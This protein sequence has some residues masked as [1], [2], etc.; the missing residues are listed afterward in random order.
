MSNTVYVALDLEATDMHPERGEIIELGAI[1]FT[2][3]RIVDRWSATVRPRGPV[4]FAITELTG[5]TRDEVRRAAPF[6]AVAPALT[7]FLR[8][9]PIVGQ[10]VW[11][12]VAMLRAA[13]LTLANPIYD[14]FE[15][16]TLTLPGLPAYSLR[17]I[18]ARLAVELPVEH[19]ALADAAVT[20]EVFRKLVDRLNEFDPETIGEIAALL[21]TAKSPLAPLVRELARE[22]TRAGFDSPV[23]ALGAAMRQQIAGRGLREERSMDALFLLPRQRPERLEPTGS[24]ARI[25]PADLRALFAPEGAFA[26]AFPG[27][28]YRVSQLRMMEAVAKA[29]NDGQLLVAEA[30]TG[31]GKA[32]DV[33]TPI[34]TPTGWKR[35]GD[36]QAGD[37]V[38]DESGQ[39]CTVTTAWPIMHERPC[40]EV[41]FSDGST[42]IADE[43]HLWAS[44]TRSDRARDYA[45]GRMPR[46]RR[47]YG[48]PTSIVKASAAFEGATADATITI[49]ALVALLDGQH[50]TLIRNAV[51][52]VRPVGDDDLGV[53]LY[54]TG[55]L[56]TPVRA[57]LEAFARDQ[58]RH[59]ETPYSV[60]T[61]A[62]ML[63]TLHCPG[64]ARN[65][66][67]RTAGIVAYPEA[68][69]PIAPYYLGIWLGDGNANNSGITTADD[70]VLRGIETRGY[71]TRKL[72][73]RYRYAVYDE[74]GPGKNRW[75]P[76][77]TRSLRL[78]GVLRNKHVPDLYLTASESQRRDLLAGLLDSGGT[79]S[80]TGAIEFTSTD[81]QL[82]E[83][84][85]ELACSLG[86][87]ATIKESRAI[88]NGKDCGAEWMITFTTSDDLF[89]LSRKRQAQCQRLR[90]HNPERN[91]YRY[92]VDI[93]PVPSRPVRC[94]AVDS[95]THLYLAGKTFIP[96]HNSVAYLIPAVIHAVERGETVVIST[97]TIGL[98]DQLFRKDI[99][100]VLRVLGQIHREEERA[101]GADDELEDGAESEANP[102]GHAQIPGEFVAALLKGRSNYLCLRRWFAL[103]K[104]SQHEAEEAHLLAKTMAW[105]QETDSGDRAELLLLPEEGRAW[106]KLAEH[107]GSC[108]SSQC[109]FQKRGQCFLY[110]A[111]R[112][113]ESAQI[114]VVNHALLLSDLGT[115]GGVLPPYQHLIID[116]AHH[117][118]AEATRQFGF[119]LDAASLV[120]HLDQIRPPAGSRGDGAGRAP[121]GSASVGA[122]AE[123]RARLNVTKG[124]AA[125]EAKKRVDEIVEPVWRAADEARGAGTI[126]FT[127]LAAFIAEHGAAGGSYDQRLRLIDELRAGDDW[128]TVSGSWE[129]L[130]SPLL[131][132]A[133]GLTTALLALDAVGDELEG[134]EDLLMEL[135]LAQRANAE[136]RLNGTTA[137]GRPD[138][139]AVYWI[140]AGNDRVALHAAPLHVGP[141]L[142][143][144]LFD[145]KRTVV[146]TSATL[147]TEG[148]FDF[149]RERLGLLGEGREARTR[150]LRVPSPFDFRANALL[151][152]ADDIPEPGSQGYQKALNE[153]LIGLCTAT[154]GRA[155]ALF[156]S[157]SAL[158]TTYRAIKGPLERSGILVLGQ[159]ID[160]NPRQLLERFRANPRAII[161]GAASFWEGVDV[162]GDALSVLAITRLPFAVPSDPV[163]AARGERFDDP[164]GDYAVPHAILRFKQGFGRLD[165]QRDRSRRLRDPRSPRPL[166][167][168][169]A[170]L[171]RLPA[172]VRR[173]A[174]PDRRSRPGRDRLAR[175]PA[176]VTD[177][178]AGAYLSVDAAVA[179][180]ARRGGWASSR[181]DYHTDGR[182]A[183][184]P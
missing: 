4:P 57:K 81:R 39:P 87:R 147:A 85:R 155:M 99:P 158:Q 58:R 143:K 16:A 46:K 79:V 97:A 141:A 104:Q 22:K 69:L 139:N 21:A 77:L 66:A 117:L 55:D 11:L 116:E 113:A 64:G 14:T 1:K 163:F 159:R 73:H 145:Q 90:N 98:Q 181:D 12:D 134:R 165:P 107:E 17:Q 15:L 34:P 154:E 25:A 54:R 19:R 170:R 36:L 82:A 129:A 32:L 84:V 28:E 95:P 157:Y 8:T 184:W 71:A 177:R 115:D 27:Y 148:R 169:R 62:E 166:E 45:Y 75:H 48:T 126:F 67:M 162:V 171:H 103:R 72:A 53:P 130:H 161:L 49:P 23:G 86:Y 33:D 179:R 31:T 65:H 52:V 175:P 5:I 114:V 121:A 123:I 120:A 68:V 7:A 133:E 119:E 135:T 178:G 44:Y 128:A 125:R 180:R 176:R 144:T 18:A 37:R 96:T 142:S 132:I 149:I 76:S 173:D 110:R 137:I 40:Y 83:G 29:F 101:K 20:V 100:D 131:Q 88:L 118:E 151:Y 136:L 10:S 50:Q 140:A 109:V 174:R 112:Q 106:N 168:L 51:R 42:I 152:L 30:Q 124:A 74:H 47:T 61:T 108:V 172:A 91:R 63:R 80:R 167:A 59:R 41:R 127:R 150:E 153:A 70:E 78:L 182:S 111:R 138:P 183:R 13:G 102:K 156:T 122:L 2:A 160:G 9:H 24:T 3:E 146:L 94:I 26:R 38:F 35:M 89:R 164:F 105:L 93:R 6:A 60:L 56:L 92:V 43:N